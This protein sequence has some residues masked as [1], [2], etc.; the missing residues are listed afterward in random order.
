MTLWLYLHFPSIQLDSF[1]DDE[2]PIVVLDPLSHQVTQANSLAYAAGI[3][4]HMGLANAAALCADLHVVAHDSTLEQNK[5]KEI[6][7]WLYLITADIVLDPPSGLLIRASQ[8]LL[9]YDGLDH[10]WHALAKQLNVRH[11]RYYAA[12][13][14]SP[15]AAKMLAKAGLTLITEDKS[16]ISTLL[17]QRALTCSEIKPATIEKLQRLGIHTLG[18]L[19]VLPL[20]EVARR[21][22]ID[23]VNYMGKITGQFKHPVD[24]YH[25]PSLFKQEFELLYELENVQ[26]LEKPLSKLFQHLEHYL[27]MRDRVAF[28]L[29][30]TLYQR[31]DRQDTIAIHSAQGEYRWQKWQTLS[32][33]TLESLVLQSAVIR[34]GLAVIRDGEQQSQP[35]DLF[36]HQSGKLTRLELCSVLQAK[37]GKQAVSTLALNHDPRP[38]KA[39][40]YQPALNGQM[41]TEIDYDRLRPSLLLPSPEPLQQDVS[42]IHGPERIVSGW[43]DGESVMRDYF[44]ARTQQG[45]WLWVFRDQSKHWFLH[46]LFS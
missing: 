16:R 27:T 31:D 40:S 44:I 8:M 41:T 32:A 35:D 43:W 7:Q 36:S 15:L 10:Y 24:F 11:L 39:T 1:M 25:P 12:C 13:G 29:A 21:F 23:L 38:E 45:Q 19:L 6:A 20:P 4:L 18:E 33:L 14:Y 34:L 42:L 2:Q 9:L 5:L 30:L 26:W 46:G 17:Q 37:L 3:K 22:D 28:E